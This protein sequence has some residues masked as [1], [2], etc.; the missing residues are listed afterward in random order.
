[1]MLYTTF[2]TYN[3]YM[4]LYTTFRTHNG[5]MMLYTT[6]R[7]Y[8]GMMLYT[9]FRT[10]NGCMM[11]YTTFRTHNGYMMLYTQLLHLNLANLMNFFVYQL[12]KCFVYLF[13]LGTTIILSE[14]VKYI[15]LKK[16]N[17]YVFFWDHS[18]V[19][20]G[21]FTLLC[22]NTYQGQFVCPFLGPW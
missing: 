3:G 14:T 7:T 1:M 13:L 9:T 5:Y 8:N 6:F 11:I 19:K 2:R 12:E 16:D 18:T 4:M 17:L 15:I 22:K 21:L 20:V 10:H